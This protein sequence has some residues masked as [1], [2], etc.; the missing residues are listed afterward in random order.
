M[1]HNHNSVEQKK[2][3]VIVSYRQRNM[4]KVMNA[5]KKAAKQF[6][7]T[8]LDN[9]QFQNSDIIVQTKNIYNAKSK[10]RRKKLDKYTFIQTLLRVLY[11]NN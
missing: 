1:R 11:K 5:I 9:F 6:S 3:S 4:K 2:I 8:I 7:A 10:I